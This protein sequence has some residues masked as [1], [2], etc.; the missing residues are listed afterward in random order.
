MASTVTYQN[1]QGL[2]VITFDVTNS[3]RHTHDADVTEHP[4]ELGAATNDHVRA[5]PADLSLDVTVTDYPLSQGGGGIGVRPEVGRAARIFDRLVTLRTDGTVLT[6]ETGARAYSNMVLKSVT[7]P[8][9]K[10]LSGALRISLQF[11][12]IK[13]VRSE[14]VPVR[15]ASTKAKP[16]VNGGKQP[17]TNA[18]DA[19]KSKSYAA[20]LADKAK[21]LGGVIS[22]GLKKVTSP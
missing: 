7:V 5:K 15:V 21:S 20:S 22:D 4:L 9:D 17:G 16:K 10:A 2:E 18:D 6:V 12:E 13:I 19:K 3:E 11:K 8:R 14:S 1:G